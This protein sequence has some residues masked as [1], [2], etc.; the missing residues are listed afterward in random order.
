MS[1][2]LAPAVEELIRT[3]S[4][5]P[6][7]GPRSAQRAAFFLLQNRKGALDELA[8]AL[9]AARRGVGRCRLCNT[10]TEGDIC[11]VCADEDRDP[12]LICVVESVAD[13]MALDASLAWP[14]LYFVLNGRLSPV[15]GVGPA[16]IGMPQ[17]LKRIGAGV[18]EGV[19]RE[20]VVATSYTP[21]GDATAYY[22]I[23]AL[24]KRWPQL[25]VTRLARGLPS[26]I[27]IE[28]TDLSTI[29]NAVYSR[30]DV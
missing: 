18:E 29:A 9:T 28:Y 7:L 1:I 2:R 13:Q 16:D 26:G 21:E 25:R 11:S 15:E 8:S 17:L 20:A 5:L 14:G 12:G 4:A 27:E 24:K 19:L 22:L 23:D 3:L 30:R 6:G 10:F